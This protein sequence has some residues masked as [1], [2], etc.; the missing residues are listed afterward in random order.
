MHSL[1][2][3]WTGQRQRRSITALNCTV[4]GFTNTCTDD[5]EQLYKLVTKAVMPEKVTHDVC[6]QSTIGSL[7]FEEFV[8]NRIQTNKVNYGLR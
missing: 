1:I 5:S 2:R 4:A 6:Q 3:H 7:L 8:S